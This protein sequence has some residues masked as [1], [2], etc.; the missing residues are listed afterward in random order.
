VPRSSV[1]SLHVRQRG[2]VLTVLLTLVLPTMLAVAACG[3]D[4]PAEVG[5]TTFG[6]GD[7]QQLPTITGQTLDSDRITLPLQDG[8]IVVL[9][10]WASWCEPCREEMPILADINTQF[11]ESGVSVVGLNVQDTS[12]DARRFVDQVGV[13]FPSIVDAE[14][15]L[16]ATIPGVPPKAV[17]STVILDRN[18]AIA[19]RIIGPLDR[20]VINNAIQ[21]LLAEEKS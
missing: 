10:A 6:V 3:R 9:N 15:S 21:T 14:G 11:K 19:V 16:L 4:T 8:S 1:T 17:P 20:T 18:G 12:T 5:V 7:R 13:N 2:T